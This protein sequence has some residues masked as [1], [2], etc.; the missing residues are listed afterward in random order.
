[1]RKI[2]LIFG[3]LFAF[4]ACGSNSDVLVGS[5]TQPIPGQQGQQ[6]IK[7]EKGGKASS[8]NMATLQYEG[9]KKEGQ[10]LI[11]TG[12]SIGNGQTLSFSDTLNIVKST[13]DQ[14]VLQ[15]GTYETTYTKA[16]E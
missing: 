4:C 12:K 14:L 1:M 2:V 11:L 5:W 9:W 16:K 10:R 3:I 7:L 13:S 15:R 8:I 6:G